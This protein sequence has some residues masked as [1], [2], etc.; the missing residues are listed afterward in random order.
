MANAGAA[1][2]AAICRVFR[3]IRRL[4]ED[5]FHRCFAR[6]QVRVHG[7]VTMEV[8]CSNRVREFSSCTFINGDHVATCRLAGQSV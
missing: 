6:L 1:A 3:R 8:L 2:D 7:H 4:V 5:V